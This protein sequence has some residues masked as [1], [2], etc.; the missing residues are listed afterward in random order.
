GNGGSPGAGTLVT[1]GISY[2]YDLA[3]NVVRQAINTIA[4]GSWSEVSSTQSAY[5]A[6]GAIT[7]RGTNGG[8]QEQFRYDTAGHL[9]A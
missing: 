4:G 1:E 5:D 2:Q 8:W 3:G 7:A 6:F 9:V